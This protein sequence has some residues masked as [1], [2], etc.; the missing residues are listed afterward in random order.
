MAHGFI[1]AL[2]GSQIKPPALPEVAD[3]HSVSNFESW[4]LES[5]SNF[6]IRISYLFLGLLVLEAPFRDYP[7]LGLQGADL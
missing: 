2:S 3:Y 4:S 6:D 5:V 7:K 1:T